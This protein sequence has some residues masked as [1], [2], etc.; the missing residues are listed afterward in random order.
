MQYSQNWIY[1]TAAQVTYAS[2]YTHV[3]SSLFNLNPYT[4]GDL[5][6]QLIT[7]ACSM[8]SGQRSTAATSAY[9]RT[10]RKSLTCNSSSR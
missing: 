7:K 9:R 8:V 1:G 6:L 2:Q 10:I 4:N 3:N 5:D